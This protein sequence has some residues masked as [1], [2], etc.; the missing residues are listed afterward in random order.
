MTLDT[1]S[2]HLKYIFK[3]K[4]IFV[5]KGVNTLHLSENYTAFSLL[6]NSSWQRTQLL[7]ASSTFKL[8]TDEDLNPNIIFKADSIQP[9]KNISISFS[10]QIE[11]RKR[12]HPTV[13][14]LE[15]GQLSDI[16]F[17]IQENYC[18]QTE[19]WSTKDVEMER[20]AFQIWN[21]T[22]M[23][24]NVL[25]IVCEIADWI[26]TNVIS[27][28]TDIP[29]YPNETFKLRLGDCDDKANLLITMCR[30]LG[31]PSYLQVGCV[32]GLSGTGT[33]WESHLTS[34][35]NSV[36]FHAWA[37][38]YIPPWG[39]LPF[40][41]TLGW[42]KDN[43]INGIT[44]APIYSTNTFQLLNITSIDWVGD[45]RR[46]KQQVIDSSLYFQDEVTIVPYSNTNL[47]Q[48]IKSFLERIVGIVEYT[49]LIERKISPINNIFHS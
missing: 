47:L 13:T 2:K 16:P 46:F 25:E 44:L 8:E 29:R 17:T 15:S 26:G 31:I 48:E 37:I 9:G 10:L 34:I 11:Q 32:Y 40:D 7:N 6:M 38:I 39:W 43:C 5:N 24:E 33:A 20:L 35:Y 22:G 3:R 14:L 27:K 18:Q 28:T 45:S 23:S 36:S 21:K 42:N 19:T 49:K 1:N 41:M 30:I 4:I 12:Q